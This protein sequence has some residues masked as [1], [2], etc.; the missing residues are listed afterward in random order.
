MKEAIKQGKPFSI[1][2]L[3]AVKPNV[4]IEKIVHSLFVVEN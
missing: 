4:Q 1:P 2:L 3:K